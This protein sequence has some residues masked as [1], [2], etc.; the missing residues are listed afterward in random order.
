MGVFNKNTKQAST[1]ELQAQVIKMHNMF[2]YMPPHKEVSVH[3]YQEMMRDGQIRSLLEGRLNKVLSKE[4][5]VVGNDE[6]HVTLISEHKLVINNLIMQVGNAI[7]KGMAVSE[8]VWTNRDGV[9]HSND[10]IAHTKDLFSFK[11]GVLYYKDWGVEKEAPRYKFV[12]HRYGVEPD[13][14][15]GNGLI[16]TLYWPWKFKTMGFEYW[17]QLAERFGVPSIVALFELETY[18]DEQ[19]QSRA[20]AIATA[21]NAISSGSSSALA[22]VRD[23]K[24]LEATGSVKDF[25]ILVE[26]C[27][28]E[29]SIA[30]T[31]QTLANLEAEHGTRAQAE[32]H[33]H[34]YEELI[35]SDVR[36]IQQLLNETVV[37][38]IIELNYGVL[39]DYPRIEFNLETYASWEQVRD[40]MDRGIPVDLDV[41]YNRYGFAKPVDNGYAKWEIIRDAIDRGVPVS[42]NY[43]YEHCG[44]PGPSGDDDGFVGSSKNI[45]VSDIDDNA[46]FLDL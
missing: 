32:V 33:E 8:L 5:S 6:A 38:W 19:A 20:D 7:R 37:K 23:V 43:L 39:A 1:T 15:H 12:V 14:P 30:I 26:A 28:R 21:I 9:W 42:K 35:I 27:N 46:F 34:R 13:F 10:C 25:N 11:N 44:L 41:L 4:W 40:A 2:S 3:D 36:A 24:A 31:G 29:I 22:N 17:V 18:D 45:E 16:N